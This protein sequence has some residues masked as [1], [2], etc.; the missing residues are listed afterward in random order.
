MTKYALQRKIVSIFVV[1]AECKVGGQVKKL[2]IWNWNVKCIL[3][4]PLLVL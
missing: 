4:T 1:Q 3:H 2:K